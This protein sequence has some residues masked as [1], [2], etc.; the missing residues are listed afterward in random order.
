MVISPPK[1]SSF[2]QTVLEGFVDGILVLTD[3]G[4]WIHA[5]ACA[6]KICEQLSQ[7]M[8]Q[9]NRVPQEIWQFC[10][11]LVGGCNRSV[12]RPM[13][14]EDE[15]VADKCR[16]YRV[17]ARWLQLETSKKPC[18][19]VTLEDRYQSI[20]SAAMAE[21][22]KYGLTPREADVWLRYRANYSYKEIAAELFITYN[23]V[24]K[25]MKSIHAKRQMV[26]DAA[27]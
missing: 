9:T 25:H 16:I 19:L 20:R 14:I 13:V 5:N 10:Q 7:E 3:Q 24:K 17:R 2:L 11:S 1:Q 26:L 12:D 23:T 18:L 4:E 22:Q 15:I 6:Q 8:A 27:E 21:G